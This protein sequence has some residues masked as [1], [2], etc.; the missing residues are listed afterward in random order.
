MAVLTGY[1]LALSKALKDGADVWLNTPVVP[2]EAS[3]TSGMTAAM[4]GAINLSTNDGWI[5][6][7]AKPGLNSFIVPEADLQATADVRD[8]HDRNGFF[9]L[10][11]Q[12]ILPMYYDRPGRGTSAPADPSETADKW[13][14]LVS[15]SMTDVLAYFGADRM[16]QEYYERVY[17]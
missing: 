10:L 17:V 5:C 14:T 12:Q 6:E 11:E 7:F 8:A 3:G 2:R 1:E 16:G 4:N 13:Q 9:D 15:R